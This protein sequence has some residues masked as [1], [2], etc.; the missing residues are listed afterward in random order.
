[1]LYY[2]RLL[3]HERLEVI[4]QYRIAHCLENKFDVLRVDGCGEMMEQRTSAY[5]AAIV[6]QFQFKLLDIV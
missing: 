6:E 1:M 2:I 4:S 5:D 3:Q